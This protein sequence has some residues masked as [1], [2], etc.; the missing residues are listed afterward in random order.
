[1]VTRLQ[2]EVPVEYTGDVRADLIRYLGQIVSGLHRARA[3]GRPAGSGTASAGLV[4]EIAAAAARH[5]DIGAAV[6]AMF[7]R[8]NALVL[9]LLDQARENGELKPE[10]DPVVVFDQLAGALYYRLLVT[11]QPL[12]SAYVD[13]L[14]AGV[15]GGPLTSP[16]GR[17]GMTITTR[18]E[19]TGTRA[20]RTTRDA[21]P[22]RRTLMALAALTAILAGYA[23]WTNVHVVTLTASVDIEATPDQVWGVLTDLHAYP[24]WNPFVTSA[25]VTSPDGRLRKGARL[26]NI[27][28]DRTGD[29]VLTPRVRPWNGT[30]SCAGSAR[31]G[32]A[33]SPTA[34]T[35][36]RCARSVPTSCASRRARA[37]P[38]SPSRS[39]RAGSTPTPCRSSV[40]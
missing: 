40:P 19:N 1:V 27:L 5:A 36:S 32:S 23:V 35:G 38:E 11:G 28:H 29:T 3:A 22:R 18:T 31:W 6:Q 25:T 14:V 37:S 24:E 13:R 8:R 12:D 34:S 4:A 39:S 26:R 7:A 16:G 9:R 20:G 10:A 15:L 17:S 33:A 21:R 30:A 2:D